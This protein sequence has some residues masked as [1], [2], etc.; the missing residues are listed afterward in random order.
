MD[1]AN[2]TPTAMA[3][4]ALRMA[5]PR[6]RRGHRLDV[7]RLPPLRFSSRCASGPGGRWRPKNWSG[8]R[9]DIRGTR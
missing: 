4:A 3:R 8:C 9:G 7:D 1:A 2:D 6:C 5:S